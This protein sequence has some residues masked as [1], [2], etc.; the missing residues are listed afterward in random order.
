MYDNIKYLGNTLKEW[1]IILHNTYTLGELYCLT[2]DKIDLN[3]IAAFK[4]QPYKK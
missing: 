3:K 2:K 4:G 1:Q